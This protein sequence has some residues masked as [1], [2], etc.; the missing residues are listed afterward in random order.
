MLKEIIKYTDF[1][2]TPQV[3]TL[4]FNLTRTEM[5]NMLDLQPRLS[6]WMDLSDDDDREMTTDEIKEILAIVQLLVKA[7]YGIRSE[8][9]KHFRKSD[10]LFELFK[11]SA[12]YDEFVFSL[13]EKPE[14]AVAFMQ[15][16]MPASLVAEANA[17]LAKTEE[18]KGVDGP[19]HVA[20]DKEVPAYIRE[21]RAPTKEEYAKL[22]PEEAMEAF[23]RKS[24]TN[25]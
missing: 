21:G 10:E 2:D 14:K 20:V 9:G 23:R 17:Q 11:S 13:F 7:A 16:V 4:Y 22:T 19:S 6:Q 15:G 25:L 3:E 1:N 18:V 8:D 24:G 5:S 12:V